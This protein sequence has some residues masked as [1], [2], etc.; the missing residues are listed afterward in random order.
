MPALE[1]LR[2]T[3]E[4]TAVSLRLP[5]AAGMPRG[6]LIL[7]L[8]S[9]QPDSGARPIAADISD[10]AMDDFVAELRALGGMAVIA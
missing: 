9:R 2:E 7:R 3:E 6:A 10:A 1:S 5:A 8:P 4:Q